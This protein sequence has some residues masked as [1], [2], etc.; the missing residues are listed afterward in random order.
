MA[1]IQISNNQKKESKELSKKGGPYNKKQQEERRKNVYRMY[2]E[3]GAPAVKIADALGVN[4]STVT[5][6]I[7]YWYKEMSTQIGENNVGV[8]F[9][10]QLERLEIL[11]SRL[12][13]QVE[14]QR[15]FTKHLALE[16]FLFEI[17]CKIASFVSKIAGKSLHI[18][19]N[20]FTE[21]I[22]EKEI[23]ELVRH[24]I[25]DSGKMYSERYTEGELLKEIISK[26]KC[27]VPYADKVVKTMK[28]NGLQLCIEDSYALKKYNLINFGTI[29]SYSE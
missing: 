22:S 26:K 6:D 24:L 15:N 25:F 3:K 27:D 23:S 20:S 29:N 1:S 9:L 8:I 2:F 7:Q 13:E 12:I 18:D 4:R 11:R 19:R 21:E 10:K 5:S 17:E 28:M 16:K 14:K